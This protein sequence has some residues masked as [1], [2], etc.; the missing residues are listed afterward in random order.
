MKDLP[1]SITQKISEEDSIVWLKESNKYIILN[2]NILE[3][4]K[5]NQLYLQ[6]NS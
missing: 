2:S 4:I 6:K 5:K 3:L 1:F